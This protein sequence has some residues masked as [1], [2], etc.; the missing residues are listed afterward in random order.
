MYYT[1]FVKIALFG[2]TGSITGGIIGGLAS[3]YIFRYNSAIQNT[4][5][6]YIGNCSTVFGII[7]GSIIMPYKCIGFIHRK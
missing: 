1:I 3:T 5:R 7:I 6:W 2:I 4:A